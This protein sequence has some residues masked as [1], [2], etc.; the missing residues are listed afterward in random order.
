MPSLRG[1]RIL[2][3]EDEYFL[4]LEIEEALE[5]EGAVVL[6]PYA[7]MERAMD[8]SLDQ[9]DGA[10]LN[11]RV[12]DGLS[13]PLARILQERNIPFVFA[14]AQERVNEPAEWHESVWVP[15]PYEVEQLLTAL[16]EIM[17]LSGE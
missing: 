9:T 11:V 17:D 10:I 7:S 16:R 5:R 14:S 13:Y 1:F 12:R 3:L 6:G 15:K 8:G 2:V 4:A